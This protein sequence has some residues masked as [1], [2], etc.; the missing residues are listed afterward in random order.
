MRPG[1]APIPVAQ[2]SVVPNV[3]V[4]NPEKLKVKS[5]TSRIARHVTSAWLRR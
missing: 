2:I 1:V 5:V 3:L 4:I